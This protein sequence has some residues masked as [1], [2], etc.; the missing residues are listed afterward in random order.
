MHL[1]L[2][3][4]TDTINLNDVLNFGTGA[5][6]VS[7]ATGL[8]FPE[9]AAQWIEG[10]GDGAIYRGSRLRSRNID[11]PLHLV[12]ADRPRL[13]ELVARLELMLTAGECTLRWV[14]DDGTYWSTPVAWQGGGG[15][16]Y[17]V[18]TIG[19]RDL[20]TVVTLRAGSPYWTYSVSSSE[21]IQNTGSGRGLLNGSLSRLRISASQAIGSIRL[22]NLGT[23]PAYPVWT[24]VGPGTNFIARSPTGQT[25]RW[26]G[27]IAAGGSITLDCR[28][29]T[30]IDVAGTNVYG[31]LATAPKFWA[32]PPGTS[33]VTASLEST[34]TASSIT[35][36]WQPRRRVVI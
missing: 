33:V 17:G 8:G 16:T 6:A 28:K 35:C 22:V 19:E 21:R 18:D 23:A 32:I 31:Q 13:K 14:E 4:S 7:G 20:S 30:A 25:L 9:V 3:N 27:T 29:G 34:T 1:L 5:Q 26:T 24:V 10:A 11:L 15:W 12:A 36:S 2:V